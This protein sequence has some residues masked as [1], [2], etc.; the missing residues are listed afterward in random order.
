M[1]EQHVR[2]VQEM[3]SIEDDT[4]RHI[5][6][7]IALDMGHDGSPARTSY[8]TIARRVRCAINTVRAKVDILLSSGELLVTKENQL[9]LYYINPE[10]YGTLRTLSRETAAQ[11]SQDSALVTKS[12]IAELYQ[13]L[14]QQNNELYQKLYQMTVST[15]STLQ[16]STD[17]EDIKEVEVLVSSTVCKREEKIRQLQQ[18]FE[19]VAGIFPSPYAYEQEWNPVFEKWLERYQTVENVT[20]AIDAAVKVARGDNQSGKRYMITS[21][22]S[23]NNILANLPNGSDSKLRISKW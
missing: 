15:V 8:R 7:V 23:L 13:K 12:D 21:P 3:S 16:T 22:M 4:A 9:H 17:T 6:E 2:A 20:A 10:I 19:S 11:D 5:L 14:Y 1:A 18:H